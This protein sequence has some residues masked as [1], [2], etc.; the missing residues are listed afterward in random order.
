MVT[1]FSYLSV[2]FDLSSI[3]LPFFHRKTGRVHGDRARF[4]QHASR[5]KTIEL[6]AGIITRAVQYT[7]PTVR[8]KL[9]LLQL[10]AELIS[11]G[12]AKGVYSEA[13]YRVVKGTMCEKKEVEKKILTRVKA[14][15]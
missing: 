15:W 12:I 11:E 10:Q 4:S 7:T 13:L 1:F 8:L 9:T 2:L 5:R 3:S 14:W 6:A